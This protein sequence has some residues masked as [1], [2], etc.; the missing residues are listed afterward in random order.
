MISL[1][2]ALSCLVGLALIYFEPDVAVY[3]GL[4]GIVCGLIMY[5][6]LQ[7]LRKPSPWPLISFLTVGFLS[8]KILTEFIS[9]ISLLPYQE[10]EGFVLIPTSHLTG[11]LTGT[12]FFIVIRQI[13]HQARPWFRNLSS[14]HLPRH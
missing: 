11:I 9:G 12:A 1:Y 8:A 13:A 7:L 10:Q 6:C 3:G 5:C 2:L 4:S 14:A